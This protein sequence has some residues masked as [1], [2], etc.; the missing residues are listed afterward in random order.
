LLIAVFVLPKL[1]QGDQEGG[2]GGQAQG[3]S[4]AQGSR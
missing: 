4:S 1:L 3:G 2:Q